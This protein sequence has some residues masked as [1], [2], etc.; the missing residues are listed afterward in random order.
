MLGPILGPL[1]AVYRRVWISKSHVVVVIGSFGKTT[2]AH[3]LAHALDCVQ[4]SL[5]DYNIQALVALRLFRLR[6]GTPT[7]VIEVGISTPGQMKAFAHMTRPDVVV[8]TSIGEEHSENLGSIE[9]I[10]AE[11]AAMVEALGLKGLAIFNGDDPN[12]MWM[13]SRTTAR[14]ITCGRGED[15]IVRASS[16]ELTYPP[17]TSLNVSSGATEFHLNVRLSG[18]SAVFPILAAVALAQ[19]RG[20]STKT[21]IERLESIESYPRRMQRVA[22]PNGA[23]GIVDDRKALPETVFAA[24]GALK[25]TP[26]KRKWGVVGDIGSVKEADEESHYRAYGLNLGGTCDEL[27]LMTN[28]RRKQAWLAEA[29]QQAGLGSEHIL[30]AD[31]NLQFAV[32]YLRQHLREGDLVLFKGRFHERLSR[33]ALALGGR[34]VT[35]QLPSCDVRALE[36]HRCSLLTSGSK[37]DGV[38]G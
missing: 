29:A 6:R 23:W 34:E 26:A 7:A 19:E 8:V 21:L 18:Y 11:K 4:A 3:T 13:K 14:A 36:C 25:G 5:V 33:I 17:G 31:R 1:A 10:R 12:V 38:L 15:N 24:L 35:C 20:I 22:L 32:G 27:I 9:N 28:D 37:S 30:K 2:T 16:V